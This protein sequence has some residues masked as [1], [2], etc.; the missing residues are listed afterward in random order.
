[1]V[2]SCITF[3][4][5]EICLS[6]VEQPL[7]IIKVIAFK[8]YHFDIGFP[9]VTPGSAASA[10]PDNFF[11]MQLLGPVPRHTASE[12]VGLRPKQPV[13]FNK[14]PSDSDVY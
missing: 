7:I 1:M 4:Y 13:F 12:S 2:P 3:L 10:L 9:T 5:L 11:E 6:T 14:L 8:L